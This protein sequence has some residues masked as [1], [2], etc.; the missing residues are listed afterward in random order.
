MDI[1][2]YKH[3]TFFIIYETMEVTRG[4]VILTRMKKSMALF[5]IRIF[6]VFSLH[7]ALLQHVGHKCM[8]HMY[9]TVTSGLI[10]GSTSV[11]HF[12]L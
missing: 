9:V 11:I 12:Q 10:N 5:H 8:G 7:F 6:S 4:T 2:L 1:V 3:L